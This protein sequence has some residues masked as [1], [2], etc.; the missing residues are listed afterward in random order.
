[1]PPPSLPAETVAAT[2]RRYL[3]AFHLLTGA[4]LEDGA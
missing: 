4:E 3:E 2:S 1:V